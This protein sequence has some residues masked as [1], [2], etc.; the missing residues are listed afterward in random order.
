MD[1]AL[2]L[3]PNKVNARVLIPISSYEFIL[4]DHPVDL[5]LYANNYEDTNQGVKLLNNLDESL[6]I[7]KEG[8][9]FAKGTTS[10]TGLVNTFFANPFGPMQ[11]QEKTNLLID[12]YFNNLENNGTK[13][14][15]IYTKLGIKGEESSGPNQAALSLLKL[16]TKEDI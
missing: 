4:N 9:R 10:E 16:L 3:N 1:R 7:F 15:V 14:G 8:Y 11:L 12:N 13:I 5:L 6:A 2:F